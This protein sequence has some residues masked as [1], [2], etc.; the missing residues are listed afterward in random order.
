LENG[1]HF[2]INGGNVGIGTT[3]PGSRL[4]I[5]GST[6]SAETAIV[7][8]YDGSNVLRSVIGKTGAQDWYLNDG[9][10]N[11]GTIAFGTP[12]SNPGVTFYTG[13]PPNFL[14]RF[15]M[16]NAGTT[17]VLKYNAVSTGVV[18]DNTGDVGIGTTSPGSK[19]TI[20]T[21]F[22]STSGITVDSNNSSD[23]QIVLRKS[24]IKPAFSVLSWESQNYIGSG[25]YYDGSAWVHHSNDTNS[26]LL[27]MLPS[28]GV[29]WYSS[30]NSTASF[31]VSNAVVLWDNGGDW[32]SLVQST[33][34]GSS[35][36]TGGSVGIG[37]TSPAY[38]LDV[39]GSIRGT[40]LEITGAGGQVALYDRDGSGT[41][42]L[43]NQSDVFR[44]YNG[45]TDRLQ[46]SNDGT[47]TL[48]NTLNGTNAS[49]SGTLSAG[50]AAGSLG[51]WTN[52][53]FNSTWTNYG[54]G[55]QT[56]QYRRFGDFVMLRGT[57][58]WVATPNTIAVFQL[59]VGFRPT[60]GKLTYEI[61]VSHST[62]DTATI[63]ID[64]NGNVNALQGGS[65]YLFFSLDSITFSIS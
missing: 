61:R 30:S 14:N 52:V 57:F 56:C 53:T 54:S 19:L 28:V 39:N 40:S 35:Y 41:W 60:A 24:S 45:T 44:L 47:L 50:S 36:F 63:E 13:A 18:I 27:E 11:I 17:F 7:R 65:S 23:S 34:T 48:F 64:T 16:Y 43:Y 42:V 49:F 38:T 4:D 1:A 25:V 26:Q 31:N 10:N 55:Y 9:T 37:T 12:S 33:R 32:T 20:G 58:K 29:R 46:L 2:N 62:T 5:V 22:A 21:S 6:I 51:A 15:D 3:S 8:Y 59:P